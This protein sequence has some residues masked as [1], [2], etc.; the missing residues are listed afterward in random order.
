[1]RFGT[2]RSQETSE[3]SP[4]CPRFPRFLKNAIPELYGMEVNLII[5]ASMGSTVPSEKRSVTAFAVDALILEEQVLLLEKRMVPD[6][7]Q[8]LQEIM[9]TW[10]Y[11]QQAVA[12]DFE[13]SSI[14]RMAMVR[15]NAEEFRKP[16]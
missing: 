9:H 7:T 2:L 13:T 1:M 14:A 12:A 16:G 8:F 15:N 3:Y 5:N 6:R 10:G 11:R 4:H